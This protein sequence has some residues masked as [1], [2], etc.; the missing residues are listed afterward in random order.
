[1]KYL[2]DVEILGAL[3]TDKQ[4]YRVIIKQGTNETLGSVQT[5]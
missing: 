5:S 3:W 2:M 1:M 4:R